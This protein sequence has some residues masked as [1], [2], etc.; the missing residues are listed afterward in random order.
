MNLIVTEKLEN[1]GLVTIKKNFLTFLS[2]FG[3]KNQNYLFGMKFGIQNNSNIDAYIDVDV[4]FFCFGPK[5]PFWANLV[6]K[7]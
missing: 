5:Y 7:I 6:Q 2:K 4:Q 3:Q 1:K